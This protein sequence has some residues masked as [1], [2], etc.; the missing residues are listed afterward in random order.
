M[1]WEHLEL[2]IK[3]TAPLVCSRYEHIDVW[4]VE[5]GKLIHATG[6][7]YRKAVKRFK[8]DRRKELRKMY[9]R[10]EFAV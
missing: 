5:N 2:W 4:K 10:G 9:E 7:E 8:E 3:G 6:E 1:K